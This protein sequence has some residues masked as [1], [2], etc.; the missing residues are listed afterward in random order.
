MAYLHLPINLTPQDVL[1]NTHVT[2]WHIVD[3]VKN[4]SVAE[5]SFNVALL[6]GFLAQKKGLPWQEV[7]I[8]ALYHDLGEALTGDM[9]TVLKEAINYSDPVE[10]RMKYLGAPIKES[11]P[12]YKEVIKLAD[13]V[14]AV[15]FLKKYG[16]GIHAEQVMASIAVKIK[17]EDALA[18]LDSL[19]SDDPTTLDKVLK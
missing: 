14:D 19:L 8:S 4:Q 9:P 13:L 11:N 18:L 17:D 15:Y 1:R 2:R 3:F 7:M 5:H 12:E 10:H 6:A 16:I